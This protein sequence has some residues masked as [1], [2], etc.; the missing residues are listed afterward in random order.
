MTKRYEKESKINQE[1]EW[2]K[3]IKRE[4]ENEDNFKSRSIGI[5]K[6]E[7]LFFN[8]QKKLDA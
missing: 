7:F 2:L 4:E 8:E 5:M 3:S 6:N 1:R